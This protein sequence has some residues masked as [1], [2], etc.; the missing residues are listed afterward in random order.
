MIKIKKSSV[1]HFEISDEDRKRMHE[2]YAK[3]F[4]WEANQLWEDMN[5]YLVVMTK[6]SDEKGS[7][8]KSQK[9][10]S[11]VIS[12]DD[13]KKHVKKVKEAGGKVIG[14]P[15]EI[16][17]VGVYVSFYDREGNLLSMIEPIHGMNGGET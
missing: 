8:G 13:I 2:F 4:G 9:R 11:V 3:V 5:D 1:V 17:T 6:D 7:D 14:E 12:V 15:I 16:P 10:P